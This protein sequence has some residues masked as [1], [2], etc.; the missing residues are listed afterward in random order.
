[1]PYNPGDNAPAPA[2]AYPASAPKAP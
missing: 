2:A 1:V